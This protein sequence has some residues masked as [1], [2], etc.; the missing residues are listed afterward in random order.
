[1]MPRICG[2]NRAYLTMTL[3]QF[4]DGTRPSPIMHEVTK[5]LSNELIEKLARYFSEGDCAA[6]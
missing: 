6:R 4:R 2:Q 5:G 3:E 1:L